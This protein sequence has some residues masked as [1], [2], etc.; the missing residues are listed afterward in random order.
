VAVTRDTVRTNI[1]ESLGDVNPSETV[2]GDFRIND[3]ISRNMY[4]IAGR[5]EMPR[6]S[7]TSVS[8]SASTYE[9]TVSSTTGHTVGQ[10]FLN[11][12]GYE[13]AYVPWEQFNAYYRQDTAEPRGSG[14]PREYT[15]REDT[16]NLLRFRFGPTPDATD[17]AKVHLSVLPAA[18]TTDA[19]SIPFA[20]DLLRALEAAC[21]S[22]IVLALDKSTLAKLGLSKDVAGKW[23]AESDRLVRGYNLRMGRL[24]GRQDRIITDRRTR[25]VG[26]RF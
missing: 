4:A 6:S 26:A 23:S 7:V 15:M 22:E 3:V 13:L 11:S 25:A 19:I 18:L 8:L 24:G 9:Y 21:L 1:R 14:T 10:V 5:S 16:S 20:N 17:T 12:D 2:V